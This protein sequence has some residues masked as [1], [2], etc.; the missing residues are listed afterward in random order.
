MQDE[1]GERGQC[2]SQLDLGSRK[3]ER[4]T[5]L[6]VGREYNVKEAQRRDSQIW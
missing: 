1:S 6:R 3:E 4:A 5:E 2:E